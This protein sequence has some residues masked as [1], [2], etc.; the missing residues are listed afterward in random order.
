MNKYRFNNNFLDLKQST[1]GNIDENVVA[2]RF[3]EYLMKL[4]NINSETVTKIEKSKI[5][6]IYMTQFK[7]ESLSNYYLIFSSC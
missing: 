3:K 2:N 7:Q 1:N 4:Y 6:Q 5:K